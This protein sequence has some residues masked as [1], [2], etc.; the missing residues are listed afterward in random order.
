MVVIDF[1]KKMVQQVIDSV[2][3]RI[4]NTNSEIR[5]LEQEER[6]DEEISSER[7]KNKEKARRRKEEEDETNRSE[8]NEDVLEEEESEERDQNIYDIGDHLRFDW[9]EE[10]DVIYLVERWTGGYDKTWIGKVKES[11]RKL[12]EDNEEP[13]IMKWLEASHELE[14]FCEAAVEAGRDVIDFDIEVR[15][16]LDAVWTLL[17]FNEDNVGDEDG[18]DHGEDEDLERLILGEGEDGPEY[19]QMR[20]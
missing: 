12:L 20:L 9:L 4:E 17:E 13:D 7:E 14:V 19:Y 11:L 2:R 5:K 6:I 18:E 16:I 8:K 10:E 1:M 15:E 3:L